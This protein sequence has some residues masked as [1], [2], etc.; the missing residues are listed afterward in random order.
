M[1][2]CR[3]SLMLFSLAQFF[4]CVIIAIDLYPSRYGIATNYLSELGC[5]KDDAA[6]HA[7][8]FNLSLG[9]F[10]VGL[11]L[12]FAT[13]IKTTLRGPIELLVIGG[14]GLLSSVSILFIAALPW[15]EFPGL[16]TIAMCSWLAW[17]L[18]AILD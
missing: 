17:L 1:L 16:H 10:A 6:L 5:V 7:L 3:S 15:I 13:L 12:F 18:P 14:F 9:L 4:A 11:C 8:V 2:Q